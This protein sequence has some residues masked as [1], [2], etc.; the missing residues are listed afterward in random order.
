MPKISVVIPLYNKAQYIEQTITTV[1]AQTIQDFEIVVVNDASSDGGELIVA[2]INDPRIKL[3][4]QKNAGAGA[5]RNAGIRESSSDLIA[6]L[7]ADDEWEKDHLEVLIALN[8]EY[9]EAGLYY[10]GYRVIYINNI[11]NVIYQKNRGLIDFF[12]PIGFF[13]V[14]SK[15]PHTSSAA[16]KRSVLNNVGFFNL[17][18]GGEEGDL[19]CRIALEYEVVYAPDGFSVFRYDR[20]ELMVPKG[21]SQVY[22]E[23]N[24]SALYLSETI[25]ENSEFSTDDYFIVRAKKYI[26]KKSDLSC[27]LWR[28]QLYFASVFILWGHRSDGVSHLLRTYRFYKIL[29][30]RMRLRL[31]LVFL[32]MISIFPSK[33]T[34]FFYKISCRL[35][36]I[37]MSKKDLTE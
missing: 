28:I 17:S 33:I 1:L 29:P 20:S 27:F 24:H 31:I 9:P 2:A 8:E 3:I 19:F 26:N 12:E 13:G 22:K 21:S 36:Q 25:V 11:E 5:A 32:V 4:N 15:Y 37:I 23:R 35:R 10:T 34:R 7:D 18:R 6:L 16:I 30:R 14:K